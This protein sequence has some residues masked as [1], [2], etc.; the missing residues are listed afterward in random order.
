MCSSDLVA[1]LV[2]AGAR[3]R[4][5][6]TPARRLPTASEEPR[7][8]PK[9]DVGWNTINTNTGFVTSYYFSADDITTDSFNQMWSLPS[10]H[11]VH[12]LAL[13]KQRGGP[14]TA[15]ADDETPVAQPH[16]SRR[17]H[18]VS[19]SGLIRRMIGFVR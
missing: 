19:V 17:R 13:R 14:V 6:E 4:R 16:H 18:G 11:I 15:S 9:S 10:D 1:E 2:T 3:H 7:V 12:V 8:R 5:V